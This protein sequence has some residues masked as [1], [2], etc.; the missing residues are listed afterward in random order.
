M[1]ALIFAAVLAVPAVSHAQERTTVFCPLLH[2]AIETEAAVLGTGLFLKGVVINVH[3]GAVEIVEFTHGGIIV[4]AEG[5]HKCAVTIV[6]RVVGAATEVGSGYRR[7]LGTLFP[8]PKCRCQ[9]CRK[10]RERRW[11]RVPAPATDKPF[12]TNGGTITVVPVRTLLLP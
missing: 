6:T 12:D 7:A 2:A 1:K 9:E 4:A 8:L 10:V 3:D 5:V 11:K